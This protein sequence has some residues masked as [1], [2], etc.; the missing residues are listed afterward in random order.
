MIRLTSTIAFTSA[1]F[2]LVAT[3]VAESKLPLA[4][5][6]RNLSRPAPAPTEQMQP[7]AAMPAEDDRPEP[8][9]PGGKFP[10][11]QL[12]HL[13]RAIPADFDPADPRLRLLLALPSQPVLI[14]A[15][16]MIDGEPFRMAREKRL[17]RILYQSQ[18]E[19]LPIPDLE[20]VTNVASDL[21]N[22]VRTVVEAAAEA[23][24]E[25]SPAEP[26]EDQKTPDSEPAT[27]APAEDA[28]EGNNAEEGDAEEGQDEPEPVNPPT[29][30]PYSL[31][32]TV[33][34]QIRRY[35]AAT[36][37]TPTI[38][39]LR[40][41]MTNWVEG[42]TVLLLNENF[43]RFR[44]NQRPVFNVLDQDRDGTVSEAELQMAVASF[45]EWDLNQN[46]IV[47]YGEIAEGADDPRLK[48]S[49]HAGPGKLV[50]RIPNTDSAST[51]YRRIA[52]RYANDDQT[53]TPLVPRFDT[54]S[55]GR[56]DESELEA[57]RNAEADVRFTINF[58]SKDITSSRIEL[59]AVSADFAKAADG[60][61]VKADGLSLPLG[62]TQVSFSAV[63]EDVS[64]QIS[65]GAVN[66]GYPILPAIDPNDDGRF[67]IR[68]L[69]S[70]VDR[71][72]AFDRNGDG[73]LTSDEA[74]AT[75][76]VCFGLGPHVH[77]ELAELRSVNP[78][79]DTSVVVG[80][81]WFERMDRNGDHD[82]SRS[83][84][85]GDDGQ[86][87]MVDANNDGLISSV[88]ALEFDRAN[89]KP[90]DENKETVE[91]EI[92]ETPSPVESE[93]ATDDSTETS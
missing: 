53:A 48:K 20:T 23:A 18:Q 7:T 37:V 90:Q 21:F 40:W 63:Q 44:S 15:I 58:N 32:N 83:E 50:F 73:S 6:V 92:P 8:T 49:R 54:D 42:P 79:P 59:T 38:E 35:I 36:E 77:K 65:V 51:T 34:E 85:P 9:T 84:F 30:S 68:E 56:F 62:G 27:D 2:T 91:E 72:K 47:D 24:P 25:E 11:Y 57:L 70:L 10:Q 4:A 28:A 26:D 75:I 43:Q 33:P 87:A 66:D 64:D 46:D 14:D 19:P 82:L 3:V 69:R 12:G 76:R 89:R 29:V 52:T 88:E 17:M 22:K 5:P 81:E 86:F 55:D 80:P 31:P 41:L 67:T 78:K 93:A 71:L 1:I 45:K 74:Q 16:I 60:A 39:E 13:Q 61:T